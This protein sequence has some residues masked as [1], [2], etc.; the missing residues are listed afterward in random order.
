MA[1]WGEVLNCARLRAQRKH[2]VLGD[3]TQSDLAKP[4]LFWL[5]IQFGSDDPFHLWF[6]VR[7][8][9]NVMDTPKCTHEKGTKIF[10]KHAYFSSGQQAL[11]Q[12]WQICFW[13][14]GHLLVLP[15]VLVCRG[16]HNK[17]HRMGDLD[18]VFLSQF[19]RQRSPDQGAGR[20]GISQ[21]PSSCFA[22]SHLLAVSSQNGERD[23]F[24]HFSV[25]QG[26]NPSTRTPFSLLV[27]LIT[28]RRPRLFIP[29]HW[30]LGLQHMNFRGMHIFGPWRLPSS[31]CCQDG[32]SFLRKCL[33]STLRPRVLAEA[34][35]AQPGSPSAPTAAW[36]HGPCLWLQLSLEDA[37]LRSRYSQALST[38]QSINNKVLTY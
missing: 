27:P 18:N 28:S 19:W 30:G 6:P 38:C 24:S 35:P 20:F 25:H 5:E 32:R 22:S 3:R 34:D 13:L 36:Q 8:R 12:L 31:C 10:L 4:V 21:G 15:R 16:C 1:E 33:L 7:Y 9:E 23:H 17:C 29:S 11:G 2:A 26:T 37:M 14:S